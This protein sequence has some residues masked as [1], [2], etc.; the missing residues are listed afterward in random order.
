[1]GLQALSW[2]QYLCLIYCYMTLH[3]ACAGHREGAECI[4]VNEWMNV[5]R[6]NCV[7]ES[8]DPPSPV[9][10]GEPSTDAIPDNTV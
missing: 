7:N 4:L 6:N 2:R 8:T 1:M 10:P 5:S 3:P 9:V